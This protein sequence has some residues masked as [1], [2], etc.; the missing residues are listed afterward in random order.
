VLL[1]DDFTLP[2]SLNTTAGVGWEINPRTSL[3][4]DYVHD[5]GT[6][7]LGAFDRNLPASG[8]IGATN[9]RPVA[10]FTEVK[11]IENYTKS[12]YDA[13]ETQLKMHL[14]NRDS[15]QLSYTLSR[16]YR[17]GVN[18]YQTYMG[19]MRTPQEKGYS[20]NDQRHNLSVAETLTLP[21]QLNISGVFK[22]V[23]GSPMVVQAGTDLD[24]DG[25]SQ[26]DR[27]AGLTPTVGRADVDHQLQLI[28]EFR[29]SRRLTPVPEDSLKLDPYLSLDLR[30]TK[31]IPLGG[32]NGHRLELFAEGYN[33]TNH[34]NRQSFSISGNLV[35]PD[36]L[37]RRAARDA[38]QM[39]WG[40][41]Y[42]F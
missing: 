11:I 8:R 15:L 6:K 38:R 42:V 37:T 17:D 1:S 28:N 2:Y 14:S 40:A 36:Y 34:V 22:W 41:R 3:T 35:S 4:V 20:E 30:L 16:M 26:G 19:T 9:P 32:A 13:L 23:S 29:A 31:A 24:G 39:Q 27:P 7:Q 12:W 21:W 33:L 5:Y 18:H 25:Q 10:A